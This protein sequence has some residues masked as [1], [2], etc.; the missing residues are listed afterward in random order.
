M[1]NFIGELAWCAHHADVLRRRKADHED[2]AD[3]FGRWLTVTAR[4]QDSGRDSFGWRTG[5]SASSPCSRRYRRRVEHS[6]ARSEICAVLRPALWV[7]AAAAAI[8][9]LWV[10]VASRDP[11]GL[12]D[13]VLYLMSASSIAAGDGYTSFLGEP[14]AYYPPGYPYFLGAIQWFV[15]AVGLDGHLVL[16]VGIVQ[17]LLGGMAAAAVVVVGYNLGSVR[18]G[19]LAGTLFALWPNLVLHTPLTLSESLF[20]ALFCTMLAALCTLGGNGA[21]RPRAAQ[22]TVVA[23]AAACTFV[24]PQSIALVVPAVAMAWWW[25]GLGWRRSLAGAAWVTAGVLVAVAPWT[26]RNAVVMDA[27]VPMSTNTGDNLCMGF[28]ESARG[29]FVLAPQCKTDGSYI[30]GPQVEVAR[31]AELRQRAVDWVLDNPGALGLLSVRKLQATF[32]TDWDGL[33]AWESYGEDEHLRDGTRS[34]L[35]WILNG[36]YV[37][38]ALAALVGSVLVLRRR[39]DDPSA[40]LVLLVGLSGALLPVLFFGGPRFKIPAVPTLALLA[41]VA[42]EALLQR[43]ATRKVSGDDPGDPPPHSISEAGHQMTELPDAQGS[44]SAS[45]GT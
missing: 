19:V 22:A 27:F 44:G 20:L 32:S 17:A 25:A 2:A 15:D 18:L 29:G 7:G 24:R 8:R 40:L 13:P 10:L 14:T 16:V 26:I 39:R 11:D 38:V 35:R 31:D 36:Y 21:G 45:S 23:S 34:A 4:R 12:S 33:A 37:V 1:D 30:D 6:G 43:R 5:T 42:V 9:L 28:H 41:A 3:P